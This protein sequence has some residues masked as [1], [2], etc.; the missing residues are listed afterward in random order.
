M[1][2]RSETKRARARL[3]KA[4]LLAHLSMT[5]D[6]WACEVDDTE[7]GTRPFAEWPE[8]DPRVALCRTYRLTP[9]DLARLCREISAELEARAVRAGYDE[10]LG[11]VR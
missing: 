1:S 7:P 11:E 10:T 8:T 4:E 3:A 2:S 6:R 5:A 9:T